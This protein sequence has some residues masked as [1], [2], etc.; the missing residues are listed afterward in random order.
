MALIH[1]RYEPS[2]YTEEDRDIWIAVGLWPGFALNDTLELVSAI[3][4]RT[5]AELMLRLECVRADVDSLIANTDGRSIVHSLMRL[6][7]QPRVVL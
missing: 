7:L 5:D 3:G 6:G 2:P 1:P 4:D